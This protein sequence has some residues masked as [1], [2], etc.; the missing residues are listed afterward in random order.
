MK[1]NVGLVYFLFPG[2]RALEILVNNCNLT[3]NMIRQATLNR[4]KFRY[5]KRCDQCLPPCYW[6]FILVQAVNKAKTIPGTELET[7][8]WDGRYPQ[9]Y[10]SLDTSGSEHNDTC[11]FRRSN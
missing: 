1:S 7:T 4:A 2:S 10:L 11:K 6:R 5:S 9:H 8:P 3:R